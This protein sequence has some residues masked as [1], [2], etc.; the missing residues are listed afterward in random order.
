F[1]EYRAA[2]FA[3]GSFDYSSHHDQIKGFVV[4][5]AVNGALLFFQS[6]LPLAIANTLDMIGTATNATEAWTGKELITGR[7]LST[8][9]RILKASFAVLEG[10]MLGYNGV[11]TVKGKVTK[12]PEVDA[13]NTYHGQTVSG[14]KASGGK[15]GVNLEIDEKLMKKIDKALRSNDPALKLEGEV[16]DALRENVIGFRKNIDSPNGRIGEIDVETE[17]FIID[18]F[19][20]KR[21]KEPSTFMKYF[22]DRAQFINPE[23]KEVIL[24]APN[25]SQTKIKGI[26]ATGVKVVQDMDSLKSIIGG[27]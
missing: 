21:S 13:G 9:E 18:A 6:K 25:I 10:F 4:T 17:K 14:E 16:A 8:G 15:Q 27:K 20:G 12:V 1:E 2:N 26:E 23:N 22:D 24:Y 3:K 5:I 7:K 11:K 19:D